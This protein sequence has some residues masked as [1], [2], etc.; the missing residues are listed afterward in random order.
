VRSV[1]AAQAVSTSALL[2]IVMGGERK[3]NTS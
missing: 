3:Q 2:R 1:A